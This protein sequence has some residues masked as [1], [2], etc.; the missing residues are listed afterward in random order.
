[1]NNPLSRRTFITAAG[2]AV[3]AAGLTPTVALAADGKDT[4]RRAGSAPF[5][6]NATVLDGGE[7]ITSVVIDASRQGGLAEGPI[8]AS[9]FTV[10]ALGVNPLTGT[11]AYDLNRTVTAARADNEGRIT[12]DLKHGEGIPGGASLDYIWNAQRNVLLDLTYTIS[13]VQPLPRHGN[14][15]PQIGAFTQGALVSPEVDAFTRHVARSGLN[16][17][18]FAPKN[19][20]RSQGRPLIV[21]L[22]GG[23]EGGLL[24]DG[25]SYYDNETPLRGNRGALGFTTDEAQDLFGGAYVVAPQSPSMWLADGPAYAPRIREVIEEVC[26]AHNVDRD[27]IHVVGCS[28]GGYMSLKMVVE[29]PDV[30]ASAVPICG[31]VAPF[32]SPGPMVTDEQLAAINTPTWLITAADDPI[33]D[34]QANTVHAHELIPGSIMS[35]YENVTWNGYKFL[36]HF[37]WIYASHNDP[38]HNGIKLWRWMAQQH[39]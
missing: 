22:H 30:F 32:N 29:Y 33:I 36:G 26:E 12:L 15:A 18:L 23:G 19:R 21:W 37:S 5:T 20:G 2:T 1:M 11:V 3:A 14:G 34:P 27:R 7:Q 24:T 8:P 13:Q 25:Y 17:R 10:H 35:L 39:R 28:N 6:V 4:D 16:Y 9:A 31:V 38:S